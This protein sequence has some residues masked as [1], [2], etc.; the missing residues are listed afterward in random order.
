MRILI[1]TKTIG[2]TAPGIVFE[3]IVQGLSSFHEVELIASDY[4]PSIDLSKVKKVTKLK[5][6]S[7]NSRL[8]KLF[9]II[10]NNNPF[11]F[12]WGLRTRRNICK[13]QKYDLV[14]GFIS[15]GHYEGLIAGSMVSKKLK[16]KFAV[17]SV[18]AIPAPT[19]WMPYD[20][21]Y[22]G[23]EKMIK[24]HLSKPNAF[25]S[26]NEQ[27]LSYQLDVISGKKDMFTGVIFTPAYGGFKSMP[28]MNTGRKKFLYT[29]GIYGARKP[30]YILAGFK[31][32]LKKY[33]EAGLVFVG[34]V[35]SQSIM[36]QLEREVAE[37]I[38]FFPFTRDLSP[39]YSMAI[40][41]LDIDADIEDDIFLS[42][43]IMNYL[44][45]NRVIISETGNNSPSR[46]LF[47]NIP[48]IIQCSHNEDEICNAMERAI[49]MRDTVSFEDRL[50]ILELFKIE[51]IIVKLNKDLTTIVDM[52]YS[53]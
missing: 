37:R 22:R 24:R 11:D 1:I 28:L 9:M 3:R 25:F 20:A 8:L 31:K 47:K 44:M 19:G 38:E 48:S 50:S 13:N 49:L 43:K 36:N 53:I 39:Y 16:T 46:H 52:N 2:K 10:F 32:L 27:M 21:Y 35:L 29:G 18:D 40:A 51:N 5:A 6:Y 45:M 14:F 12:I 17:Y 41:F 4:D 33:P 26:S 7:F 30:D 15:F 34:T 42:S 23:L